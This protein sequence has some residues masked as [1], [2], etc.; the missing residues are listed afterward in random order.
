MKSCTTA[1]AKYVVTSLNIIEPLRVIKS[2]VRRKKSPV[3]SVT[4]RHVVDEVLQ[5]CC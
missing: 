3:S 5:Q 2:K 1:E 4:K